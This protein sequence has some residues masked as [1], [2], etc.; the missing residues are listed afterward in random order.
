MNLLWLKQETY[1]LG[2]V[3]QNFIGA[4]TSPFLG[5]CVNPF[6][7][8][9]NFANSFNVEICHIRLRIL[10]RNVH[11]SNFTPLIFNIS[12]AGYTRGAFITELK[13]LGNIEC[14]N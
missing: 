4:A 2:R 9:R 14:E 5:F 1:D 11:T 6:S 8:S 10:R 3:R 12:P 13:N 7:V